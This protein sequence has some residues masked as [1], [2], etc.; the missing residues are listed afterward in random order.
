M[1]QLNDTRVLSTPAV[2]WDGRQ[3]K[4][5]PNSL[6]YDSGGDLKVRAVSSG[7]TVSLV[8]GVN[9][10]EMFTSGKFSIAFTAANSAFVDDIIEKRNKG[11]SSTLRVVD[12]GDQKAWIEVYCTNKPNR[13]Y[14]AEGNI[15]IEWAGNM[16]YT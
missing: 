13:K 12:Q 16:T 2:Y 1:A 5:L 7:N 15:D 10:E 14:E 3:I 6:E 9:L 8:S 4:I 11:E